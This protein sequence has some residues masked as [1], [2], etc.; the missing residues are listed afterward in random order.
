[1]RSVGKT[2]GGFGTRGREESFMANKADFTEEEWESLHKGVTGAGL[3]VSVGDRDFTDTFGEAS[4]LAKRLREEHEQSASE[5][6][7]ELAAVHGSG[8]GF[9]ASPQKVEAETLEALRSATATLAA[10]APDETEAYR[11]LVLD[12]AD[13]VAN[14][15]GGVK[16]GERAAIAKIGEALGDA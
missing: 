10:K 1:V 14:A 13:A 11:R 15:K 2:D 3:L 12:I 16:E 9:T 8:F 6:V 7:R 4:A 5:L